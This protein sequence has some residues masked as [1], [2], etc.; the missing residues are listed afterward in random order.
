M[1]WEETAVQLCQKKTQKTCKLKK[2]LSL[3]ETLSLIVR[4]IQKSVYLHYLAY[5]LCH[6]KMIPD[7]LEKQSV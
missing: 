4:T 7:Y 3:E 5:I 2:N 6:F 1:D